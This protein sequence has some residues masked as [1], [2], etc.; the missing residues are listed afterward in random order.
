MLSSSPV[1][2]ARCAFTSP[3]STHFSK[4]TAPRRPLAPSSKATG[5]RRNLR[6]TSRS[7][8]TSEAATWSRNLRLRASGRAFPSLR[9][10]SVS[11]SLNSS[12]S[13]TS[14]ALSN[15]VSSRTS[16]VVKAA[17]VAPRRPTTCILRFDG[18]PCSASKA[19]EWMSVA[20]RCDEG[21]ANKRAQSSATLPWPI[22]TLR[23]WSL[24]SGN[25]KWEK[26]GSALYQPTKSRA[27]MTP[28]SLAPGRSNSLARSQPVATTTASYRFMRS[29]R[30]MTG[31]VCSGASAGCPTNTCPAYEN[32]GS[33]AT[34]SK[35]SCTLLTSGW[36]GATPYLTSPKGV[37]QRSRIVTCTSLLS[38]RRY[39]A[40]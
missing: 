7:A 10:A 31:P 2:T 14:A 15:S 21:A 35:S 25:C 4:T 27:F 12:S 18:S 33:V 1:P 36:S 39:F 19:F 3:S 38:L 34:S 30:G 17:C 9:D 26:V 20:S 37:G 28:S 32:L 13:M 23:S 22:M 11:P 6:C 40:V 24:T 16:F 29:S 5:R 8:V